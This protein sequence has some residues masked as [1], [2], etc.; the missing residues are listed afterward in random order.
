MINTT[1]YSRTVV[2]R[3]TPLSKSC[4]IYYIVPFFLDL[5]EKPQ[6]IKSI[7]VHKTLVALDNL[8]KE[9]DEQID[10]QFDKY[11]KVTPSITFN[12]DL[13]LKVIKAFTCLEN[14]EN[15][16]KL[17]EQ[18]FD[19]INKSFLY[20]TKRRHLIYELGS[21]KMN[22][23]TTYYLY[24]I[25]RNF[26]ET[27]KPNFLSKHLFHLFS[28]YIQLIDDIIDFEID[29]E[30]GINTPVTNHFYSLRNVYDDKFDMNRASDCIETALCSLI[31][32][33]SEIKKIFHRS[34][35]ISEKAL[36]EWDTFD[37]KLLKQYLYSKSNNID[38]QKFSKELKDIL[39]PFLCYTG[40]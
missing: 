38:F 36:S 5:F 20:N 39:P 11:I 6:S 13:K 15:Y 18:T 32:F 37:S 31:Y 35:S 4:S 30:K 1:A 7:A 3:K 24:P 2:K 8:A 14:H 19:C 33:Y 25:L 21:N 27:L 34:N 9:I 16:H 26:I 29:I 23:S 12:S 17:L 28:N 22:G 40:G 10:W